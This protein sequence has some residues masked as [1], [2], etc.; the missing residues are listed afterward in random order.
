MTP[1]LSLSLSV[2]QA[3]RRSRARPIRK[4]SS[5]SQPATTTL[6]TKFSTS[7][8][9]TPKISLK[10]C[11]SDDLSKCWPIQTC[12]SLHLTKAFCRQYGY[13]QILSNV[14][15]NFCQ[16]APF[17]S[18]GVHFEQHQLLLINSVGDVPRCMHKLRYTRTCMEMQVGGWSCGEV[19][20]RQP[21]I[22]DCC[23]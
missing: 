9:E 10:S 4:R 13:V 17:F 16:I 3:T 22:C 12:T 21:V 2:L 23:M 19:A 20:G 5:T 15:C 7:F 8:R 6:K 11:S 1:P 18:R 14:L